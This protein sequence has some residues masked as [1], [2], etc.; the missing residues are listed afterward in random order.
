[1][2]SIPSSDMFWIMVIADTGSGMPTTRGFVSREFHLT[3]YYGLARHQFWRD[4][5]LPAIRIGD[6]ETVRSTVS[7]HTRASTTENHRFASVQ[8]F[9]RRKPAL[10]SIAAMEPRVN[11]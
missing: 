2:T 11:L 1:L 7:T 9:S 4:D 6:S 5:H 3:Q 8:A 10:R